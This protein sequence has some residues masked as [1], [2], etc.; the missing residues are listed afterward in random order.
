MRACIIL[1]ALSVA[2]APDAEAP[3]NHALEVSECT[4]PFAKKLLGL[5]GTIIREPD[6][7]QGILVV[8]HR[9]AQGSIRMERALARHIA[10]KFASPPRWYASAW[11]RLGDGVAPG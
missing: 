10:S 8:R 3:A 11:Q 6:C 4:S 2:D 7:R 5:V 1:P 9:Q